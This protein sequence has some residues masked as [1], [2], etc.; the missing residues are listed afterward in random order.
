MPRIDKRATDVVFEQLYQLS[1]DLAD[2]YKRKQFAK[3]P[4]EYLKKK[5]FSKL[6]P[7]VIRALAEM[8]HDELRALARLNDTL[9]A[10]GMRVEGSPSALM[11]Y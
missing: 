2:P 8:N 5:D 10:A 11:I 3:D 7:R 1:K 9:V 6:P 4:Q